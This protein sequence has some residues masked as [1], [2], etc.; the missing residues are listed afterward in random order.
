MKITTEHHFDLTYRFFQVQALNLI[1]A[2]TESGI[3]DPEKITSIIEA[4]I[5][6]MADNLDESFIR[7]KK[8]SDKPYYPMVCFRDREQVD[9]ATEVVIPDGHDAFH[10]TLPFGI[11]NDVLA[12]GDR[13]LGFTFGNGAFGNG[14]CQNEL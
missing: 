8:L 14:A 2:L 6:S 9:E 4:F 3:S 10:E 7:D 13:K 5:F 12:S 11:V 1:S